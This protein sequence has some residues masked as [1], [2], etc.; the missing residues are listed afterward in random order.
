MLAEAL[1]GAARL[2]G[3]RLLWTLTIELVVGGKDGS[4]AGLVVMAAREAETE[5]SIE[6]LEV[7]DFVVAILVSVLRVTL[8][9]D[10]VR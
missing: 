3:S 9:M 2:S 5:C 10:G 6:G 1:F 8:D 7:G 4:S